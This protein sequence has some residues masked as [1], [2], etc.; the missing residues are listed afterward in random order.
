MHNWQ[1]VYRDDNEY[2]TVIVKTVLE[3]Y[4]MNPVLINKKISSYGFGD[5]EILVA[6]NH[7]MR[8]LKIISEDIDFG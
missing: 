3:D 1:A 2:R 8:A 4:E 7:I 6:P 5:Y